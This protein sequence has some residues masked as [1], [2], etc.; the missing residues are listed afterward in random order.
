[1]QQKCHEDEMI[2]KRIRGTPVLALMSTVPQK[3]MV[4]FSL[5][6]KTSEVE[7]INFGNVFKEIKKSGEM[8]YTDFVL[9]NEEK[10]ENLLITESRMYAHQYMLRVGRKSIP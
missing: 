10:L 3:S 8:E 9:Y 6:W 2:L 4:F 5:M 1:M 7:S